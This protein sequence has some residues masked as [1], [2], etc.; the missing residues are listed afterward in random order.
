[1][2]VQNENKAIKS[3]FG[4]LMDKL[5]RNSKKKWFGIDT[6]FSNPKPINLLK[7]LISVTLSKIIVQYGS[8]VVLLLRQT[9]LCNWMRKMVGK[10]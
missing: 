6:L 10:S 8:S 5:I 9:Q 4:F 2:N 3:S 7:Y 1:M